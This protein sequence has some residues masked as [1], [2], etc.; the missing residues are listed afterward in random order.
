[1]DMDINDDEEIISK[2][3]IDININENYK[4]ALYSQ[5]EF[6]RKEKGKTY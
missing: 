2:H 3:G 5:V 6:L 4:Y 1:M